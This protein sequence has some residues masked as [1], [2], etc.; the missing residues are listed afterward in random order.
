MV[1]AQFGPTVEGDVG[2]SGGTP[3]FLGSYGNQRALE[4]C[5]A[6]GD[7]E[8]HAPGQRRRRPRVPQQIEVQRF[9]PRSSLRC[10]HTQVAE[11]HAAGFTALAYVSRPF[12]SH[13]RSE[14]VHRKLFLRVRRPGGALKNTAVCDLF[15]KRVRQCGLPVENYSAY[16]LRHAF[17]MRLLERGVGVKAIGDLLKGKTDTARAWAHVRDDAPLAGQDPPAVLFRYSRNRSGPRERT[18]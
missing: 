18:T 15:A 2:C 4:L 17:A 12:L 5:D 10:A 14:Y 1:R 6:S 3:S 7:G 8:H 16:S 13:A 9:S 11:R